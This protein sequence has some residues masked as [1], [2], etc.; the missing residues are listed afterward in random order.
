[1]PIDFADV[2]LRDGYSGR[3]AYCQSKLAQILFTIDL[4]ERLDPAQ[5]SVTA[6]HPA[7][8]MPTK[9]VTAAGT[10]PIS[11]LEEGTEA[12]LRLAIDPALEGVTG[13]YFNGTREARAD[14]QAYDAGARRRLRELS[15]ELT[16]L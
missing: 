4:A 12:T 8:F 13:R 11:T 9:M 14:D 7:T 5:V 2:M 10:E 3:R 15:D 1:M 16:A 6:L